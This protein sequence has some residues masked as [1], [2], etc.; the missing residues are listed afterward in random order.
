V[1]LA[2]SSGFVGIVVSVLVC[3]VFKW[4][5]GTK[6]KKKITKLTKLAWCW[7]N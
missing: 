2:V 7:G 5:E 3:Q 6:N 4:N 1:V